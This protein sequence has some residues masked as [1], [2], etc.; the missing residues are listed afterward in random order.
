MHVLGGSETM[1]YCSQCGQQ[2]Q[3]E[4]RYCSRCG[5]ASRENAGSDQHRGDSETVTNDNDR[6][7]FKRKIVV[8]ILAIVLIGS[9]LYYAFS[10]IGPLDITSNIS[11]KPFKDDDFDRLFNDWTLLKSS[12]IEINNNYF[13]AIGMGKIE[14]DKAKI[15]ISICDFDGSWHEAWHIP[16]D[17]DTAYWDSMQFKE[18]PDLYF[19]SLDILE[20]ETAAL[21]TANVLVGGAHG[22]KQVIAITIDNNGYGKVELFDSA[23]LM[24]VEKQDQKIIVQGEGAFSIHELSLADGIFQDEKTPLSKSAAP[25]AIEAPFIINPYDGIVR[26]AQSQTMTMK[27]GQTIAFVPV[28]ENTRQ[29]FDQGEILIY[30]DA[31]NGPPLTECEANRIKTG[32]S[33]TFDKPGLAHFLLKDYSDTTTSP[34][35]IIKVE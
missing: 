32:N 8:A 21:V 27:V 24:T 4:D 30:S 17:L 16:Q 14:N 3:D 35:F 19:Q 10:N 31:W 26:A 25:Y 2:L 20:G 12:P 6:A 22:T 1:K 34:T 11:Y 18:F 15:R 13:M 33:Y 5:N 9:S 29:I 28:D 7:D 23:G